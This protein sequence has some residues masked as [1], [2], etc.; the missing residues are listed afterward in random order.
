MQ[1]VFHRCLCGHL[2]LEVFKAIFTF[3]QRPSFPCLAAHLNSMR[4]RVWEVRAGEWEVVVLLMGVERW[5]VDRYTE[6]P[7]SP[8]T[9]GLGHSPQ[10]SHSHPPSLP[11]GAVF[12]DQEVEVSLGAHTRLPSRGFPAGP[13]VKRPLPA[14]GTRALSLVPKLRL[15]MLPGDSTWVPTTEPAHTEHCD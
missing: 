7:S 1:F 14:P 3:S 9:W 4:M 5:M 6:D 2:L 15:H 13:G 10:D 8:W 11:G 12:W